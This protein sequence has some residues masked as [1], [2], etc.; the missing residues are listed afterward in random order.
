M[1]AVPAHGNRL[2]VLESLGSCESLAVVLRALVYAQG[3]RQGFATRC[4]RRRRP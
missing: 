4:P 2:T 1:L 3:V